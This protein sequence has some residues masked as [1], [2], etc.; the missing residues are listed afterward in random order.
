MA[1]TTI[2]QAP[3]RAIDFANKYLFDNCSNEDRDKI[4][5]LIT[6]ATAE[7]RMNGFKHL[8]KFS[9]KSGDGVKKVIIEKHINKDK[10]FLNAICHKFKIY[11]IAYDNNK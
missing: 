7:G 11:L 8:V 4:M 3:E 10:N 1:Q 5:K 2:N 9:K 6:I